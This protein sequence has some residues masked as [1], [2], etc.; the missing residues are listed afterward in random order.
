MK[1]NVKSMAFKAA[2]A[3]AGVVGAVAAL[4]APVKW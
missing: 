3:V 1:Q 4:G 2:V